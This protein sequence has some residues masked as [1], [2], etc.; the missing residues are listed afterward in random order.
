MKL[1]EVE[2]HGGGILGIE[3][4]GINVLTI[5]KDR[6]AKM[7]CIDKHEKDE[8]A[9][10]HRYTLEGHTWPVLAAAYSGE[11]I[12]TS[13]K[14][15]VRLWSL[16]TGS[17][18]DV[19]ST[20]S[21][22]ADLQ[23]MPDSD[24]EGVQ[25]LGACTDGNLRIYSLA[26]QEEVSC[27]KG[28]VGVIRKIGIL[29]SSSSSGHTVVSAGYDGKVRVWVR[30]EGKAEWECGRVFTFSDAVRTHIERIGETNTPDERSGDVWNAQGRI[31]DMQIDGSTVYVVGE[32]PS[33]V[34]F[35]LK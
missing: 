33:I 6:S 5:S 15:S 16:E 29:P 2:G 14:D 19:I 34:T 8:R 3:G 17:C 11:V 31:F 26:S 9:L 20:F 25:I 13:S 4:Q 12:I 22:I 7:W 23:V 1:K 27:L 35:G 28:H 21:S 10:I 24:T 30:K 32:G 18:I